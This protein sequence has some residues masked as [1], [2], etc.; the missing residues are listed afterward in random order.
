MRKLKYSQES[1]QLT[2]KFLAGAHS[3]CLTPRVSHALWKLHVNYAPSP[4]HRYLFPNAMHPENCIADVKN[5]I[6]IPCNARN[7]SAPFRKFRSSPHRP[8]VRFP[9]SCTKQPRPADEE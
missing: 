3:S 8:L 5:E 7:C 9:S 4:R 1:T 6:G 2:F